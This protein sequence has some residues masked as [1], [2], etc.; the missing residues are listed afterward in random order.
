M[1]AVVLVIDEDGSILNA[2]ET[3]FQM[4]VNTQDISDIQSVTLFPNPATNMVNV[5]LALE[6]T[7]DINISLIDF[8][9][10]VVYNNSFENVNSNTTIPVSI[11]NVISGVYLVKIDSQEGSTVKRLVVSN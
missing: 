6:A 4:P 2:D 3:I 8:T 11:E 5:E 9:G 10:K 7:T 1:Q